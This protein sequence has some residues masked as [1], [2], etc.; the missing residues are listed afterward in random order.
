MTS[1]EDDG[2]DLSLSEAEYD[3]DDDDVVSVGKLL[4]AVATG[5]K[6]EDD[7]EDGG[8]DD[9]KPKPKR[10]KR[11][12]DRRL[13]SEL[14]EDSVYGLGGASSSS[15]SVGI[16]DLA[17]VLR[18]S[19]R[20]GGLKKRLATLEDPQRGPRALEKPTDSTERERRAR[21]AGYIAAKEQVQRWQETIK[22]N[23]E[24]EHLHFPL[25]RPRD[26]QLLTTMAKRTRS[27][28]PDTP[29]ESAVR[30]VLE[31]S[32]VRE[33]VIRR[34]EAKLR[35]KKDGAAD[36]AQA[37]QELGLRV[38]YEHLKARR[39]KR[40]KSRSFRRIE[41]GRRAERQAAVLEELREADP[42]AA[43]RMEERAEH[44]RVLERATLRHSGKSKWERA[45]KAKSL[46]K[47]PK[48][49]RRLLEARRIAKELVRKTEPSSGDDGKKG[50]E[51]EEDQLEAA[52]AA[53]D[54]E[55]AV[56]RA[57]MAYAGVGKYARKG[58]VDDYDDAEAKAAAAAEADKEA[59]QESSN[60]KR[61]MMAAANSLTC[62]PVV[63]APEFSGSTAVVNPATVR[64]G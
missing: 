4:K 41:R 47:D 2:E 22:A 17:E 20:F 38:Y 49:Q 11:A 5:G 35:E 54:E 10:A 40:I 39:R 58:D 3:D 50:E 57:A 62:P 64:A 25:D 48:V 46:T 26:P 30:T 53:R 8:D 36:P 7:E 29:L 15:D 34:Y 44:N 51:E 6:K 45:V 23:R 12:A 27:K 61:M 33:A 16:A 63:P 9:G 14:Y 24:A 32:G 55:L 42:E 59:T 37:Q 31:E 1:F 43:R 28:A 13:P 52:A 21:E 18:G 60:K 56:A 19:A